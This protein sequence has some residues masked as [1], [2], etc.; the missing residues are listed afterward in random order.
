MIQKEKVKEVEEKLDLLK[1]TIIE[2]IGNYGSCDIYTKLCFD[3]SFINVNITN[4]K[5]GQYT[6]VF[7]TIYYGNVIETD[8]LSLLSVIELYEIF[9]LLNE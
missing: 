2:A 9:N 1:N 8:D 4:I 5:N 7:D 3:G 6:Y